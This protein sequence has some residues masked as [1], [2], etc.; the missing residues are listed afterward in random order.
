MHKNIYL[1]NLIYYLLYIMS[2]TEISIEEIFELIGILHKE[3]VELKECC[4]DPSPIQ[5]IKQIGL[6]LVGALRKENAELKKCCNSSPSPRSPSSNF[7]KSIFNKTGKPTQPLSLSSPV[8]EGKS[9]KENAR[10]TRKKSRRTKR[11]GRKPTRTKRRRRKKRRGKK[12][13]STR[14]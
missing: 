5:P 4:N 7:F 6:Q 1:I 14:R 3:N 8:E 12:S 11:R 2:K 10:G 13:K 9:L